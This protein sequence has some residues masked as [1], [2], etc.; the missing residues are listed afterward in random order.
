MRTKF[1]SIS[2][3]VCDFYN[4]KK[5]LFDAGVSENSVLH[6]ADVFGIDIDKVDE[7][8]L[9]HGHFDHFAGLANILKRIRCRRLH[10]L[11]LLLLNCPIPIIIM[12]LI[13]SLILM[14]F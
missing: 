2:P 8:I 9:S 6:N 12:L 4:N 14:S 5:F 7:I 3:S 13:F 11:F 1:D 10:N